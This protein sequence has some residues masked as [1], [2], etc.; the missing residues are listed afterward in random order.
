MV[1]ILLIST[2]KYKQFVQ[3]LIEQ[4]DE[5]FLPEHEKTIFLFTD[6]LI[7]LESKN[8]IVQTII[9]SYKF[10][11]AT[12]YRFK[13]FLL[14]EELLKECSHLVYMDVDMAIVSKVGD[15][16]LFNGLMVVWHPGF[17]SQ[18][19]VVGHWGSNGVVRESKAWVEPEK[20]F[21]YVAGGFNGGKTNEFLLMAHTLNNNIN[22]D[23]K[24]GIIAEHND[25][26]HLNAYLK[27]IY[28][29]GDLL[30][31]TPAYCM[32]EQL[33]LRQAWG[34]DNIEPKIIALEKKHSEIR[35]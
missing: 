31:L 29:N 10:P 15:E 32:V 8:Y 27:N 18:S 3:K 25:E 5:Y 9:T 21:N 35:S 14:Q 1:G 4:I 24:N 30:Y 33:F 11:Y 7:E 2:G 13:I 16:I 23:E 19:N 34:I 26:S 20:R 12:L 28:I 17:F 22:E 6:E